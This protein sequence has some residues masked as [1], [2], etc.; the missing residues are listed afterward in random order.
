MT[1]PLARGEGLAERGDL[2][3]PREGDDRRHGT[4]EDRGAAEL[5][6][7]VHPDEHCDETHESVRD[8]CE[9][10]RRVRGP[11]RDPAGREVG[12]DPVEAGDDAAGD[13]RGD[14]GQ[15][16]V[17]DPAQELLD[18]GFVARLALRA[19]VRA[20][21]GERLGARAPRGRL[22]ILL[23]GVGCALLAHRD[24]SQA[25]HLVG[26]LVDET[27]SEDDLH[28]RTRNDPEH[29]GDRLESGDV[30]RADVADA[31]TQA[32]HAVLDVLD[33]AGVPQRVEHLLG[34][35]RH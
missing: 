5:L 17:R 14:E 15:E 11:R 25:P 21:G 29:L 19:Q 1:P 4:T 32:G 24:V 22:R 23:R 31:D 28:R 9:R 26:D 20:A 16:D 18:R 3:D 10:D 12:E 8:R 34:K 35:R 27:R 7:G 33:V 6:G 30:D 2:R 13:E